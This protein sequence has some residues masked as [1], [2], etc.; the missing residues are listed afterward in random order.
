MT[1]FVVKHGNNDY[2]L[3]TE[4]GTELH[5][6]T[7]RPDQ[8]TQVDWLAEYHN[9]ASILGDP[10]ARQQY[11]DIVAGAVKYRDLTISDETVPWQ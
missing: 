8:R 11:T 7:S 9:G 1:L 5:S 6:G 10:D 3:H 4:D 2:R